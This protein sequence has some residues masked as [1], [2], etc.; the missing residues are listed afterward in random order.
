MLRITQTGAGNAL[1]VEDS[2][3][4]DATPFVVTANGTVVSGYTSAISGSGSLTA[5]IQ[6]AA[7]D[8][9]GSFFGTSRWTASANAG[10]FDFLKSR[11]ATV[12]TNGI[13]SS[14]DTLGQVRFA[15]D[16]GSAFVLAASISSAV[17]GTPGTNDMPGRLVF[18]TTADGGTNPTE[19]MRITSSGNIGVGTT[20]PAVKLAISSTDAIL[21]PVGTTAQRPTGATGYLRF[22]STTDSFEGYN[23][24]AWSPLSGTDALN[25]Q[26]Y[27]AVGDG[28][29]DDTAAVNAWFTDVLTYGLGYVPAGTYKVTS[30]ITWDV[31]SARTTGIRIFGDSPR[32]SIFTSNISSGSYAFNITTTGTGAS[33]G[34]FYSSFEGIGFQTTS[35]SFAGIALNIGDSSLVGAF[36]SFLF[37]NVTVN[38]NSTAAGSI[39]CQLA[40]V[41]A[42]TF[43]NFTVNGSNPTTNVTEVVR[44]IQTQFCTFNSCSFANG[45]TSIN[46]YSG[47]TFAN[48]FNAVDFEETNLN[49]Q[50]TSTNAT[51]NTFVGGQFSSRGSYCLNAVAG[52]QNLFINPNLTGYSVNKINNNTG[53]ETVSTV[54]LTN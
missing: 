6:L 47:Y 32:R 40:N 20:S 29:T 39:A 23:G 25:L 41:Y 35:T 34:A 10:G 8:A 46:F 15:G 17:D 53:L 37:T 26:S 7:T 36:N 38:N 31:L 51:K 28:T 27:G 2:A 30:A 19:R 21:T 43:T 11:G 4:P 49:V 9:S 52:S 44:V 1:L 24:T 16:D 50:I 42:S 3:N 18:S 13:V 54:T 48:V 5:R 14:G 12:G 22:N 45:A 33:S